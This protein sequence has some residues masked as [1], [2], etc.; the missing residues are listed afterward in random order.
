M[1]IHQYKL[2][3][4]LLFFVMI[5]TIRASDMKEVHFPTADGGEI[6]A[7]LYGEGKHAVVLAHGAIFNK[8]SWDSLANLLSE[9][10]L[11]VLAI[12][13]R[14]YGKSRAG[15]NTR[16]LYED[17]LAAV[18]YLKSA[19]AKQ[20]SV[21][22]ASMGGGASARAAVSANPDEIY[23]L[24]LL[25]PVPIPNPEA[26]HATSIL[27]IGSEDERLMPRIRKQFL[28]A[29]E[30]KKLVVLPGD[31]HAQHIFKT[32]QAK[33]LVQVILDFLQSEEKNQ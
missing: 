5:F 16:A 27:Y 11:M 14:G 30:P 31:A 19:G 10:G 17:V 21:I 8:E 2:S 28:K 3:V 1:K 12:D 22:G 33:R 13:F 29:P 4:I 25:S 18:R 20:V 7:N 9:K 23:K 6:F 15:E 32:K 24:I 26:I